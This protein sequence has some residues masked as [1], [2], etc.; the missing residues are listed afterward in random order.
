MEGLQKFLDTQRGVGSKKIVSLGGELRKF[1][2]THL[3]A[4]TVNI[5]NT[6]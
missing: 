2:V 4:I 5:F 1:I 3:K 6:F